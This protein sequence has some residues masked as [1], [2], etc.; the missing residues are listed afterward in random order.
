MLKKTITYPSFDG[1]TTITEDFYFN[2]TTTEAVELEASINGGW[3]AYYTKKIQDNEVGTIIGE[4]KRLIGLS[5]GKRSEDGKYFEK[6]EELTRRFLQSNAYD[7][8]FMEVVGDSSKA[9]EFLNSV[10][11]KDLVEQMQKIQNAQALELEGMAT[12]VSTTE[13]TRPA[14]VKEDREPTQ[15]EMRNMSKDEM[16][17]AFQRRL[18]K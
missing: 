2:L 7:K 11:P 1:E 4:L 13:D 3:S 10:M 6:S 12:G 18:T 17:A 15:I 8:L 5:F 16:V 9:A 14:W